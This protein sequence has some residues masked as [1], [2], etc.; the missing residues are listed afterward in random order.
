MMCLMWREIWQEPA[1]RSRGEGRRCGE[2][3][4]RQGL[5]W[6]LA[7]RRREGG[8]ER[9]EG[10]MRSDIQV[11]VLDSDSGSVEGV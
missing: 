4:K 8:E 2:R 10:L 11:G 3:V 9:G 6:L 5:R 1:R 7:S